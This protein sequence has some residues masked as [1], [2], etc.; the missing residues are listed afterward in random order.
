MSHAKV[1]GEFGII[2]RRR[3]LVEN[4]VLLDAI[5]RAMGVQAPLDVNDDLVT[6]GP[7]FGQEALDALSKRLTAIGLTYFDDFIDFTVVVPPWCLLH[8]TLSES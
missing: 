5:F 6:F 4:G 8:A 7:C 1:T 3:S 2:V